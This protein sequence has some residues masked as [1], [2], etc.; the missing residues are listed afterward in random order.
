[1]VISFDKEIHLLHSDKFF[2]KFSKLYVP[3]QNIPIKEWFLEISAI[4]C[5]F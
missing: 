3:Q 4:L 5:I 2:K 1:M